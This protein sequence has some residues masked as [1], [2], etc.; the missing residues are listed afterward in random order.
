MRGDSTKRTKSVNHRP[1]EEM[2][3]FSQVEPAL[4]KKGLTGHY[5]VVHAKEILAEGKTLDDAIK[6]L[7]ARFSSP[8]EPLLI[9]QVLGQRRTPIRMRSPKS[10]AGHTR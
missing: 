1:G 5:V 8:P 6:N 9:R 7:L 4:K 2:D 3:Y 10:A